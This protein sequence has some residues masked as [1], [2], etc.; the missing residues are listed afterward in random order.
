M[1]GMPLSLCIPDIHVRTKGDIHLL[2]SAHFA[3]NCFSGKF[4]FWW[5]SCHPLRTL[6]QDSYII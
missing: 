1:L 5:F 4:F 6:V 3:P 2:L